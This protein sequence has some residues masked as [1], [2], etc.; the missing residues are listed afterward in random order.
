MP[1][2]YKIEKTIDE[3]KKI[4]TKIMT[5]H[6]DKVPIIADSGNSALV[7]KKQKF[8]ISRDFTVAQLQVLVRKGAILT[9]DEAIF[10]FINSTL[11]KTS[12]LI[13][14]VY[15]KHCDEDGFMYMNVTLESTFG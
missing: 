7:L 3:R 8:I 5:K 10:I 14:D 12:S 1:S 4:S 9:P 11:P 2:H 6:P 13:G 15:D